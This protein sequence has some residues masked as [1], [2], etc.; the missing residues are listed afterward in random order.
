MT[1]NRTLAKQRGLSEQAI[2]YIDQLHDLLEKLVASYTLDVD[3]HEALKLVESVEFDLQRLWQFSEDRRYHTWRNKLAQRW[4]D[5]T[6]VGRTFRC[7]ETGVIKVIDRLVV[8]ERC[9]IQVGDG[10]LDLG[11]AGGYHRIVGNITEMTNMEKVA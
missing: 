8:I 11:V 2:Q 5:L 1:A 7:N 4:M 6:W 3:Y 9:L 10:I